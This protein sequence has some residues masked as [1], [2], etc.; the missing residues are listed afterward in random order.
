MNLWGIKLTPGDW[1]ELVKQPKLAEEANYE[2]KVLSK[3]KDRKERIKGAAETISTGFYDFFL[4]QV[5][6]FKN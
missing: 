4:M 5:H 1:K 6:L 3:V 2:L